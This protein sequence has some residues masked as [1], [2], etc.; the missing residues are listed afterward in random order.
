MARKSSSSKP[1][2]KSD[3]FETFENGLRRILTVPKKDLDAELEREK[4][5]RTNGNGK[6]H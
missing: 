1:A 6:A 4:D 3:E 2:R 5:A